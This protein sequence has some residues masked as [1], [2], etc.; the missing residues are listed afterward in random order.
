MVAYLVTDGSGGEA[1]LRSYLAESLP[2]YMVPSHFVTLERLPLTPNGKV[3]R[4]ALPAP[5]PASVQTKVE[6]VAPE[7]ELQTRIAEAWTE[8]LGIDRVGLKDNF[9]DIGGHSLLM[10]RLH[11]LLKD[12]VPKP[13]A[14]TDLYRFPTIADLAEHLG[15]SDESPGLAQSTDRAQKRRDMLKQRRRRT[16]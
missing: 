12:R 1:Q 14:M 2:E 16:G 5:E 7:N 15:G 11:R 3:D 4:R 13:L 10:V 9:F 6:F 8:V